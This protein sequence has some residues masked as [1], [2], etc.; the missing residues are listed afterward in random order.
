VGAYTKK[1]NGIF[2]Y[3]DIWDAFTE[4]FVKASTSWNGQ[5][6]GG[7]YMS[8]YRDFGSRL[9]DLTDVLF[10]RYNLEVYTKR[11]T[12]TSADKREGFSLL[13]KAIRLDGHL[14]L[15]E[16]H[17]DLYASPSA[18]LS[19]E[20]EVN[21]E[22]VNSLVSVLPLKDRLILA[23]S[24]GIEGNKEDPFV[25]DLTKRDFVTRILGYSAESVRLLDRWNAKA[26][27]KLRT[28]M[29]EFGLT[30]ED[31]GYGKDDTDE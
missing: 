4:T 16:E 9:R 22:M 19:Y 23:Y 10:R 15:T 5:D 1:Y 29:A 18:E 14:H 17:D 7:F 26:I 30:G 12:P 11:F 24:Y 8:L 6:V 3:E 31:F 25:E 28:K 21:A 2:T 27:L 20:A 13:R